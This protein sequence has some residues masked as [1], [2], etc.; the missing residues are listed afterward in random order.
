MV[1]NDRSF[2][3]WRG[4]KRC[5]V[6]DERAINQEYRGD[7]N[8]AQIQ[9]LTEVPKSRQ[10]SGFGLG[11]VKRGESCAG[12]E[13]GSPNVFAVFVSFPIGSI[14]SIPVVFPDGTTSTIYLTQSITGTLSKLNSFSVNIYL[15]TLID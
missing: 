13:A 4:E 2:P 11:R 3:V 14:N 8:R 7:S 1:P 6:C 9:Q 12:R 5:R 15:A 10:W